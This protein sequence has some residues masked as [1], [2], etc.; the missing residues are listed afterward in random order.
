MP[1]GSAPGVKTV[2]ATVIG[3]VLS[4]LKDI[5]ITRTFGVPGDYDFTVSDAIVNFPGIESEYTHFASN[6]DRTSR[7]SKICLFKSHAS[8]PGNLPE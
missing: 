2:P 3:H 4:K 5:G 8:I 1:Q 6:I 7:F